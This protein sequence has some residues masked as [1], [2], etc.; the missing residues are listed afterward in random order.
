MEKTNAEDIFKS[1]AVLT[2]YPSDLS[3]V[4]EHCRRL[5]YAGLAEGCFALLPSDTEA[6][7]EEYTR[8]FDFGRETA[9]YAAFHVFSD[10][11]RRAAFMAGLMGKYAE[12]GF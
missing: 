12:T 10:E 6:L 3:V 7:Q 9:P 11:R 5:E 2:D 4:K 8:L 1:F